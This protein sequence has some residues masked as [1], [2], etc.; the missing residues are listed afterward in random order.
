M[1]LWRENNLLNLK[2]RLFAGP[3][4]FVRFLGTL[5]GYTEGFSCGFGGGFW[6][7]GFCL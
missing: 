7:G 6:L 4:L 1:T 2:R 5:Y 3:T